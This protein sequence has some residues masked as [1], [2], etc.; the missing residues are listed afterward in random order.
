MAEKLVFKDEM[1]RFYKRSYIQGGGIFLENIKDEDL[2]GVDVTTLNNSLVSL[3]VVD[4]KLTKIPL[5]LWCR[6]LDLYRY[7]FDIHN[8]VC[9]HL[10]YNFNTSQWRILVPKQIITPVSVLTNHSVYCDISTGENLKIGDLLLNNFTR[11]GDSHLHPMGLNRFSAQDDKDELNN[12]GFHI[13]VYKSIYH[14]ELCIQHYS[15]LAHLGSFTHFGKR[16]Y[17]NFLQKLIDSSFSIDY[18]NNHK[19]FD[20]EGKPIQFHSRVLDIIKLSKNIVNYIH[21]STDDVQVK[22]KSFE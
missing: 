7:F 1:G 9:V 19:F 2:N 21:D 10:Y 13:L 11:L 22:L 14:E 4:P 20:S 12:T 8:E 3:F 15:N 6:V 16:Y 18:H 5:Y 17:F